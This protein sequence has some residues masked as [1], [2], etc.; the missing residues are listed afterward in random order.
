ME[1][2]PTTITTYKRFTV[3]KVN[4]NV[5]FYYINYDYPGLVWRNALI[6]SALHVL[7]VYGF[8]LSVIHTSWS[9]W[10]F[11]KFRLA[12]KFSNQIKLAPLLA[13]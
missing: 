9:S 13:G 10:L 4:N 8:Y 5:S 6:F 2:Q 12:N 11:S 1:P 3:E 7:Y